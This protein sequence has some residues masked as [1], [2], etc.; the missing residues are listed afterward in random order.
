[1]RFAS[2]LKRLRNTK[3]ARNPQIELISFDP[4]SLVD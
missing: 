4:F 1:M 2:K 3:I